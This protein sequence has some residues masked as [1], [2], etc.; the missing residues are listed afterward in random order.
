MSYCL[1]VWFFYIC[2]LLGKPGSLE[3]PVVHKIPSV[4]GD[5]CTSGQICYFCPKSTSRLLN[6]NQDLAS[7]EYNVLFE[8]PKKR[9]HKLG[10]KMKCWWKDKAG[11]GECYLRK[12]YREKL[13]NV[14]CLQ[15]ANIFRLIINMSSFSCCTSENEGPFIG[16]KSKSRLKWSWLMSLRD[17]CDFTSKVS[18]YID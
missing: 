17:L 8:W 14:F 16:N 10:G 12:A 4:E 7:R 13:F 1:L 3:K 5:L 18:F 9:E 15:K 11:V 2:L 6:I